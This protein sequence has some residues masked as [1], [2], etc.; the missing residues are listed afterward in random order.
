MAVY[1][2]DSTFGIYSG[3]YQINVTLKGIRG[4]FGNPKDNFL[5]F[6]K[7]HQILFKNPKLQMDMVGIHYF[8][9]LIGR[10]NVGANIDK[11][12]CNESFYG[13]INIYFRSNIAL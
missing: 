5:L 1:H 7:L 8:Q 11:N 9:N 3:S 2:R 13:T 10:G 12:L 6:F 4:S